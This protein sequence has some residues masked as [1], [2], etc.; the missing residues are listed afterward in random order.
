MTMGPT[1][2]CNCDDSHQG[3][4]RTS[5][6]IKSFFSSKG[7]PKNRLGK[8]NVRNHPQITKN[9]W[10][11]I[12]HPRMEGYIIGLP[13]LQSSDI[14]MNSSRNS[15]IPSCP[16]VKLYTEWTRPSVLHFH[17]DF[18][19]FGETVSATIPFKEPPRYTISAAS[20]VVPIG[21]TDTDSHW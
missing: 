5:R 15:R 7:V 20:I 1:K 16:S 8:P 13:T 11:I 4:R 21:D 19:W 2:G 12:N 17:Q 10:Y 18:R 9:E 6:M 14:T 3:T